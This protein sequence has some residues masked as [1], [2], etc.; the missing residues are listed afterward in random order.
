LNWW[1]ENNNE[2]SR[3]VTLLIKPNYIIK[4]AM[5]ESQGISQEVKDARARLAA[6]YENGTQ[7]G[8]KGK[9]QRD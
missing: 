9:S 2:A 6:R 5:T 8:G 3:V 1:R 7:L 4:A